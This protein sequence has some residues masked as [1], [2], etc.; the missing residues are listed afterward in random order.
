MLDKRTAKVLKCFLEESALVQ[1]KCPSA[2]T[3]PLAV[4]YEP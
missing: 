3:V 4:P 2:A 1:R